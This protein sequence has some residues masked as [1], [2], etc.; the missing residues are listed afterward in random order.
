LDAINAELAE[1]TPRVLVAQHYRLSETSVR[2]H[3][4]QHLPELL[5]S[6][7]SAISAGSHY[8]P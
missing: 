1:G 6:S 2:R 5:R 4:H 7:D 3:Y 8:S